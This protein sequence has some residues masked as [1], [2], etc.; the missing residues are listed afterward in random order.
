MASWNYRVIRKEHESG[1]IHFQIHEVYYSED[2]FIQSWTVDP[3]LPSGESLSEL[4]EDIRYFLSAFRKDALEEAQENGKP[5]LRPAYADQEINEGH[6]F[7]LMDRASVTLDYCCEFLGSHPVVRRNDK[8]WKLFE[9]VEK[10]LYELYQE[11]SRLEFER[12][13]G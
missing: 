13:D 3:V 11:A 12:S 4:R 7:E 8:L 6:Y 2:G 9:N 1:E 5:V 10:A